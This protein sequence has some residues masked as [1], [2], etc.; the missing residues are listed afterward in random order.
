MLPSHDRERGTAGQR[1][2]ELEVFSA[3]LP[4]RL[5]FRI[6]GSIIFFNFASSFSITASLRHVFVVQSSFRPELAVPNQLSKD[7]VLLPPSVHL[8]SLVMVCI[9]EENRRLKTRRNRQL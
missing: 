7:L 4:F 8:S 3:K 9:I 6:G 2:K 5:F 1:T